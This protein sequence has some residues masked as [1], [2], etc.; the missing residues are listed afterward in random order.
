[1]DIVKVTISQNPTLQLY[2]KPLVSTIKYIYI[3]IYML[4]KKQTYVIYLFVYIY[5]LY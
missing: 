3:Y 1:M 4:F 2:R 5:V